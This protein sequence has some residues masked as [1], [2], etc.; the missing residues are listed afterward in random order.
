[1][2]VLDSSVLVGIIKD[3]P[4]TDGFARS[5]R[6]RG[7]RDRRADPGR[8]ARLVLDGDGTLF[9]DGLSTL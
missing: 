2:I 4:N 7:V 6:R 1:M 3:E 5:S 9:R 8:N